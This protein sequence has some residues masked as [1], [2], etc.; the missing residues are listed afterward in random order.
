MI[1]AIDGPSASG[2]GAIGQRLAAALGFAYLD[3]GKLYRALAL[4]ALQAS[5]AL[6]DAFAVAGLAASLGEAALAHPEL[7]SDETGRAAATVSALPE[8]RAALLERQRAFA[9][10]GEAA[11]GGAVLDGRDIGTVVCPEAELKLYVT[12]DLAV[13]AE[14]R[15]RQLAEAG[16]PADLARIRASLEARDRQDRERAHAPLR[17]ASDAIV[18]DSTHLTLEQT[19]QRALAAVRAARRQD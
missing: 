18:I 15:A 9:R 2:K 10:E 1:I 19:L 12:A 6:E 8:V 4:L 7:D 13:R 16:R 3:T 14:R 11:R 5:A 17:I